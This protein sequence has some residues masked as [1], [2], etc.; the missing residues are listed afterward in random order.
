LTTG[1]NIGATAAS[2]ATAYYGITTTQPREIGLNVR[3]AFG[4][5]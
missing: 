3:F 1:Y 4:A 5:R 2:G